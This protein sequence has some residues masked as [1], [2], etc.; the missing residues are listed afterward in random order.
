[1]CLLL[2]RIDPRTTS[3]RAL[4]IIHCFK[5][6]FFLL[7]KETIFL[8]ITTEDRPWTS[9]LTA[10]CFIH[11][12]NLPFCQLLLICLS[13]PNYLF[14]H[15]CFVL[16]HFYSLFVILARAPSQTS[17]AQSCFN[18]SFWLISRLNY[19]TFIEHIC[20]PKLTVFYCFNGLCFVNWV[21]ANIC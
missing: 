5:V 6:S 16:R 15:F 4:Y 7:N 11:C 2:S 21:S 12:S 8:F 1:M 10:L 9:S 17:V 19:Y 20:S 14:S 13:L 18:V 3:L